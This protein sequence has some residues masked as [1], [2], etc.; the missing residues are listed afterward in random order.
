MAKSRYAKTRSHRKGKKAVSRRRKHR[1]GGATAL[2]PAQQACMD[3]YLQNPNKGKMTMHALNR[4]MSSAGGDPMGMCMKEKQSG[5]NY[6]SAC[7]T[8]L[9]I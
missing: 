6:V 3:T 2:T 5:S 4:C 1:G 9:G 8:Y 7:A